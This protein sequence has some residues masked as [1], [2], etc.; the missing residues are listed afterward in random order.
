M[1]RAQSRQH[2]ARGREH[3]TESTKQS[4]GLIASQMVYDHLC[5]N[6][7]LTHF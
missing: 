7:F 1:H 3:E 4:T 5:K 2:R 6:A